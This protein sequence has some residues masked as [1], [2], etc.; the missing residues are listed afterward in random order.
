MQLG[1]VFPT[2]EIGNDPIA[3][4]D[5]SQAAEEMGYDYVLFSDHIVGGNPVTYPK[6]R[7]NNATTPYHE[8]FVTM[9]YLAAVTQ[10]IKLTTGVLVLPQRQTALVAKQAAEVDVLSG[11]RLI[12]GVGVGNSELEYEAQHEDIHN[13]GRRLDEQIEVLRA[14]WTQ[15][16][17]TFHGKYHDLSDVAINP[18]PLQQPIPI[19][20]GGRADAVLER[21]GRLADGWVP[22]SGTDLAGMI[23]M[24]ARSAE[25]AG[26]SIDDVLIAPRIMD[27]LE[28]GPETWLTLAGE[29]ASL[30]A[31]CVFLNTRDLGLKTLQN[32]LDLGERFRDT[33]QT[34]G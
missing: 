3:I 23:E 11:G 1:I 21:A 4:R 26:R 9:G 18:R 28:G 31:R 15:P 22:S 2:T 27:P 20:V 6:I 13:R 32:H 5:W 34:L 25:A 19:W 12:L 14:L 7:G 33:M 10:R 8:P 17:V 29:W 30:G 16:A 24:I